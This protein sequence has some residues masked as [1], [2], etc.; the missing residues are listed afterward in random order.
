MPP[1]ALFEVGDGHAAQGD[2]EVDITAIETSLIGTFQ[3]VVRKDMHLKWPR[4]ETPTHY[5]TMGFN[6]DLNACADA[7]GAGDGGFSGDR[8]TFIAG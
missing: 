8:E 7:G 6:D 1:G 2:G 4:A 3:F 5:M